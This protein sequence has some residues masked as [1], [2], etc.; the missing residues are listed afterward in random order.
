[1]ARRFLL[2]GISAA[3]GAALLVAAGVAWSAGSATTGAAAEA[4]KGGTLRLSKGDDLEFVDPALAYDSYSWALGFPTCAKLFNY[5]DEPGAA[6]TQI[7]PEVVRDTTISRDG[8]LYTFDL[9]RTFRFHTG[10]PVTAG[11]FADAFNRVAKPRLG[12]PATTYMREIAGAVAVVQG[13]AQTISGV[14]VLGRYRLQ[15][16]LTR[17]VGDFAARLTMPFFCPILPNTPLAAMNTPPGSGPY[18]VAERIVNRR[19]VL[20]RNPYYRGGRPANVDQIVVTVGES[21]E[22]CVLAVEQ[23]RSDHCSGYDI[24]QTAYR[25]LA[26]EYGI[27][28]PDGQFF[29][30]ASLGTY[31]LAFNHNRT[32]FKGPGQIPLKKAINYAIDRPELARAFGYLATRRTDQMLPPDLGRDEGVY[33]LKGADPATARRWLA[34]ARFKPPTLV[35]YARNVRLGVLI[36]ETLRFNLKQIGIDLD[37][38]YYDGLEIVRRIGSRGEPFDIVLNGMFADYA[39]PAAFFVPLLNPNLRQADN[40]NYSY[41]SRPRVTARMNAAN[42][43]TGAARRN[44]WA[45]L[46][47]DLM[48]NDPP[49]AP[50]LTRQ[51]VT[52]SRGATAASSPRLPWASTSWPRARSSRRAASPVV[53]DPGEP[54]Q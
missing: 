28:R 54:V 16:R 15:I 42:R 29:V 12:S 44:A 10:A 21:G 41:Y 39:D 47:A 19:I 8:R 53:D 18:Y 36:A 50:F 51:A 32:A 6:G 22:A 14:R 24:P 17:P 46:D 37:V 2:S 30:G 1:M 25:R 43:L 27:N 20:R 4:R 9:K 49:W 38:K 33:P 23:D 52:S 7:V 40:S 11:S 45:D 3:V 48:R 35:F 26:L 13:R 5:P 34:K 31:Y